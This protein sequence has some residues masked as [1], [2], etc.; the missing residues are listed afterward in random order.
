MK[1]SH[2]GLIHSFVLLLLHLSCC[3]YLTMKLQKWNFL[4]FEF[5]EIRGFLENLHFL[6]RFEE[7]FQIWGDLRRRGNPVKMGFQNLRG[8]V[9]VT[10][11]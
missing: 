1:Y 7:K 2:D 8:I 3:Y 5:E 11:I 4:L 10:M 9:W 6:R